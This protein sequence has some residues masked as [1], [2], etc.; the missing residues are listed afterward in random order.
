MK[1]ILAK[2]S[3][4]SALVL[5]P[6][7]VSAQTFNSAYI[8]GFLRSVGG[9][10]D[11]LLGFITAIAF[12]VFAW[13]LIKYLT[14]AG[15]EKARGEAKQYMIWGVVILFVLVSVWGIVRLLQTFTQTQ[16]QTIQAVDIPEVRDE[17]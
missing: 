15:D 13:S 11:A 4:S 2:L 14:S 1:N 6:A 10:I 7:L 8:D 9:W 5:I 16:N 17:F 12:L 3:A